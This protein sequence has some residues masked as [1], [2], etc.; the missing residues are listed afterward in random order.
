M[1][2]WEREWFFPR[3]RSVQRLGPGNM[4]LLLVCCWE[5]KVPSSLSIRAILKSS[6]ASGLPVGHLEFLS[7]PQNTTLISEGLLF[8]NR[9]M[10][11]FKALST[12]K[13]KNVSEAVCWFWSSDSPDYPRVRQSLAWVWAALQ[14][15][16]CA[17]WQWNTSTGNTSGWPGTLRAK[18]TYTV[19]AAV[20]EAQGPEWGHYH[21]TAIKCTA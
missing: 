21:F 18:P 11:T 14:R 4:F 7:P 12:V 19:T 13:M 10:E 16:P 2:N 1:P 8:R 15:S 6:M 3:S 5:G 9:Q 20:G 17:R